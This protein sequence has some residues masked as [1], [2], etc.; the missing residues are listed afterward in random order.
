MVEAEKRIPISANSFEAGGKKFIVHSSV[1]IDFYERM[2]ELQVQARYGKSFADLHRAYIKWVELKNAKKDFD[3]DVQ[4]RNVFEGVARGVNKQ[5]DPLIL[6]CTLFCWP[7][8]E[9]RISWSE[10]TANET[11]KLWSEEGYPVEDFFSLALQF[12]ARYQ[13]ASVIA[14]QNILEQT[15]VEG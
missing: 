12:V 15:E 7:E 4:L 10:E 1:P 6:I 11:I 5:Q 13:S 8:G 3:A 2:D 9:P 14:S